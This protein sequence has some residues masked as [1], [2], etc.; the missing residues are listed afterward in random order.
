MV[1]RPES[2]PPGLSPNPSDTEGAP[3]NVHTV[4][5]MK[6]VHGLLYS[7]MV[8]AFGATAPA[9]AWG[10][11]PPAPAAPAPTTPAVTAEVAAEAAPPAPPTE[12]AAPAPV[13]TAPTAEAP[14][15][16]ETA[17]VEAAAV[18]EPV[19]AA[20]AAEEPPAPSPFVITTGMGLR[21]SLGIYS[22]D[23]EGPLDGANGFRMDELS[24]EPRFSGKVTDIVGWTANF[25][26]SGQSS[27]S[28]AYYAAPP[29]S[30]GPLP[31]RF[32]VQA[33]D[34][35]AQLDFIPEFHLWFGRMLT[36]SDR[37]NFSGP[38]FM[39]PWNYPGSY[40]VGGGPYVGPRGTEEIGREV[41]AVAWGDIAEGKF[42]YYA[43]VM[44]L[45]NPEL[46]P[47]LTARLGLALI[48]KEPGFYGSSTYYGSQ[49]ILALGVAAQYQKQSVVDDPTDAVSVDALTEVNADVLAEFN[50][51][52]AGT[53]T[54]EAAYY[55]MD[56][57]AFPVEG[58]IMA[59]ASYTTE[60]PVGPGKI[61]PLVRIQN[62]FEPDHMM[63][64]FWLS[65]VMKDYF[66][67]LALGYTMANISAGEDE[68]KSNIV[69]FGFQ[70]QQ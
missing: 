27:N 32:E 49:D 58:A 33:M 6:K 47:L 48:G 42:K 69:Q 20:P 18:A 68:I 8:G 70:I 28:I 5:T 4:K 54:G 60:K 15:A 41:G 51:A 55:Y 31:Y 65:Y 10:Q 44:D 2:E 62:T 43:G 38:W 24:V 40:F 52:G 30:N 11:T 21:S 45:D 16:E 36:P 12:P 17:P 59:L 29:A 19:E 63:F 7:V 26:A 66:A 67:K 25:Q 35:V 22:T 13:E 50:I 57:P 34:L 46:S 56:G 37:S 61:Q 14:M 64:D 9:V 23:P 1:R 39:S 3:R 53:L